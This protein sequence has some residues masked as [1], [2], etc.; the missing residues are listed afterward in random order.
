MANKDYRSE[1]SN[2]QDEG[3][4]FQDETTSLSEN[5]EDIQY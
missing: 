3:A 5:E 4:D 2:L 1:D